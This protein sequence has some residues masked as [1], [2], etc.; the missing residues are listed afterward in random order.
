MVRHNFYT[1]FVFLLIESKPLAG[2][3]DNR[4]FARSDGEFEDHEPHCDF[5][6]MNSEAVFGVNYNSDSGSCDIILGKES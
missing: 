1:C 4:S 3:Y 6:E 2:S 5:D